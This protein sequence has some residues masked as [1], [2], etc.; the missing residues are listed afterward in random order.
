[1]LKWLLW[2]NQKFQQ[3]RNKRMKDKLT[4]AVT[5]TGWLTAHSKQIRET[6]HHI[7]AGLLQ[8]DL[9]RNCWITTA[10]QSTNQISL[11]GGGGSEEFKMGANE[12]KH[13]YGCHEMAMAKDKTL[14]NMNCYDSWTKFTGWTD[15]AITHKPFNNNKNLKLT[16]L[17]LFFKQLPVNIETS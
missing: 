9:G 14:C 3:W 15:S 6:E 10:L 11:W 17:S 2:I 4:E 1:M 5:G 8:G 13:W 12:E 7:T 16:K